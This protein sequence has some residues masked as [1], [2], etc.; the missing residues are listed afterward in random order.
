MP[1]DATQQLQYAL[2][3][4]LASALGSA[5]GIIG[6]L[7]KWVLDSRR[8]RNG[9][10]HLTR[11]EFGERLKAMQNHIDDRWN[12]IKEQIGT[13]HEDQRRQIGQVHED[14]RRLR[15][16]INVVLGRYDMRL[17]RLEDKR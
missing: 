5:V 2:G 10:G 16:E 7:V 15:D 6:L 4:A 8:Q 12:G 11:D 9:H 17:I 13:V 1:T 3:V 14:Q